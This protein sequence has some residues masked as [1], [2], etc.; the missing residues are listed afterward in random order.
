MFFFNF[1]LV[2]SSKVSIFNMTMISFSVWELQQSLF[3]IG[4]PE[5]SF[6]ISHRRETLRMRIPRM[7]EGF[8]QRF[9]QSKTSEQDTFQW[10]TLDRF[11]KIQWEEMH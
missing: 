10:G 8:Q 5:N 7:Y 6:A 3:S 2:N 9:G 11:T 1:Q 4:E